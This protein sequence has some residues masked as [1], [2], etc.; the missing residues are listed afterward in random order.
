MET[1][2]VERYLPGTT[3]EQVDA[4]ASRLAEA[5]HALAA[6]GSALR[7]RGMTFVAAEEYC[8]CRFDSGSIE[9]VRR[10]CEAAGISYARIVEAKEL[11][12]R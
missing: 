7:Y 10:V 2:L 9:D 12:G 8:V 5:S 4:A 11:D 1:W 6:K 3:E